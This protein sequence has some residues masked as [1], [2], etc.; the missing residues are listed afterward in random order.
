VSRAIHLYAPIQKSS[1]DIAR[2][3]VTGIAQV[4]AA[5]DHQGDVVDFRASQRAF[6]AWPR[7][8]REM[9]QKKAVGKC[10][11][12]QADPATKSIAVTLKIS[13]GAEDTWQKVLDGTLSALSIG[14]HELASTRQIDKST[15]RTY[16]RITDYTLTEL[17]LVDSPANPQCVITAIHKSAATAVLDPLH[18]GSHMAI[19]KA[20]AALRLVA[21]TLGDN[22]DMLVIRKSDVEV[23]GEGANATFILKRTATPGVITKDDADD[24]GMM[25]DDDQT[26][27]GDMGGVDLEGHATNM[28]NAHKDLCG[29][30]GIDDDVGHYQQATAD[31]DDPGADNTDGGEGGGG[32]QGDIQ[33]GRRTGNLR[34]NGRGRAM[35]QGQI[36]KLVEKAVGS[37]LTPI[38]KALDEMRA[39]LSGGGALAPRN[40]TG[41][42]GTRIEKTLQAILGGKPG[43]AALGGDAEGSMAKRYTDLEKDLAE[44]KARGAVLIKKQQYGKLT[45]DEVIEADQL[46]KDMSRVETELGEMRRVAAG[47]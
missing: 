3:E 39:A 34:K 27:G 7:N 38:T 6:A 13:K 20:H 35:S 4:E 41:D 31:P 28:A 45:Q 40:E 21:K 22:D 36:D 26:N 47:V 46:R 12:W 16:N 2:R 25:S 24:A 9:H 37:A 17:S 42:P 8:V 5:P 32:A 43:D 15:G 19:R 33:M 11:D 44:K 23:Q 1:I 30:A 10:L 29:M 18:G 14:G